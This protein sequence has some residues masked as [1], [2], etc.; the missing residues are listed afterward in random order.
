MRGLQPDDGTRTESLAVLAHVLRGP[1]AEI[2]TAVSILDGPS[3]DLGN[4][5]RA[6]AVI[7]RE[8]E[9][10]LRLV[11]DIQDATAISTGRLG[12]RMERVDLTD[13]VQQ[14]VDS[15]RPL[16]L[17]GRHTLVLQVPACAMYVDADPTRLTQMLMTLI[18]SSAKFCRKHGRIGICL[19]R[20][21][22]DAILRVHDD[23]IGIAAD[24]LPHVF[25][26]FTQH[27]PETGGSDEGF[28]IGLNMVKRIVELHGGTVSARSDGPGA[29]S[30]FV[31]RIPAGSRRS[32]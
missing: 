13:V 19:E 21:A 27:G 18:E 29:G 10:I 6:R 24:A 20:D 31:V 14:A 2:A 23:G 3:N 28:G 11:E 26:L 32:R 8:L 15:S 16:V 17:A 22:Q 12:M 25:D 9:W 4:V 5:K 1:L 7:R 30:E